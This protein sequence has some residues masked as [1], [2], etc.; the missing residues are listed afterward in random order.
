M[1]PAH[2]PRKYVKCLAAP[3]FEE[4]KLPLDKGDGTYSGRPQ[5]FSLNMQERM[6][7]QVHRTA[8]TGD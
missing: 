4:Q 6:Y 5:D 3:D 8:L 2:W 1:T 7:L